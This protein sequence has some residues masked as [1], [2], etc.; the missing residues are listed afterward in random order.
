MNKIHSN[1]VANIEFT[2]KWQSQFASHLDCYF[3]QKVNFWSDFMPPNLND[4]LME[5]TVGDEVEVSL[6]HEDII[7]PYTTSN[8]FTLQNTQFNRNLLRGKRIDPRLGRFYPKKFLQHL[9]GAVKDKITPFRC[10]GL[11]ETTLQV[12]FNHP[13][14]QPELKLAAKVHAIREPS[15]EKGGRCNEWVDTVTSQ[16]VGF[17]IRSQNQPTDFFAD[18]PFGTMDWTDDTEFYSKSRLVTHIDAKAI[19]I[20]TDFYGL[21]LKSGMKVLDL[22]SSWKSHIPETLELASVTGLGLNQEELENN[23]QLTA[24]VIHDLNKTPQLPYMDGEFDAV[25]CTVS[26]EYLTQP[27]EVFA[28][29]ARVLKPG[30]YFMVTFSNRWFPPKVINIWADLHE[31]ERVGLVME[32]FFKSGKYSNLATY[33]VRNFPRPADDKHIFATPQSDPV[34]AVYGQKV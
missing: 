7:P 4:A 30:G 20:I 27:F 17:Q 23:Q 10:I 13:L 26:V 9:S 6:S 16:G 29:V 32:Y 15:E 34:F 28:E 33:S 2:L 8:I 12:D 31:F 21:F 18:D 22:M 11:D 3:G 14:A 5:K 1:A 24:H 25:I 19:E